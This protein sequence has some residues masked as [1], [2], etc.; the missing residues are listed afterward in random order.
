MRFQQILRYLH[1]CNPYLEE[2]HISRV[3]AGVEDRD[4]LFKVRPFLS[5]LHTTWQ[6]LYTLGQQITVDEM[7]IPWKGK[8]GWKQ[9]MKSKPVKFG[10]KVWSL[11]DSVSS[12]VWSFS[13]NTGKNSEIDVLQKDHGLST[14]VVMKLSQNLW[15]KGYHV[16]T[17]NF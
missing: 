17:D 6:S 8:S 10:A 5:A 7:M 9:Y 14:A 16:Y 13:V 12:Y 3:K 15:N 11:A 4:K 1:V 2:I